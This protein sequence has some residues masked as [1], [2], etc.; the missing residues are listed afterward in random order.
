MA[1][2]INCD[3]VD[4]DGVLTIM[5]SGRAPKSLMHTLRGLAPAPVRVRRMPL[6]LVTDSVAFAERGWNT[7]T[8]SRGS[9]AT[10][11]RVHTSSDSLSNLRGDGID[12]V[13]LLL[14]R[15]VEA[16]A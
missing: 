13:A 1:T 4:D 2:A 3:G 9:F 6:G 12:D 10:L 11:R 5:Y 16:L 15:A 8:V 7:V 14:A